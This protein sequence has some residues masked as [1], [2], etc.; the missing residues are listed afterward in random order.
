[1]IMVRQI[2]FNHQ[3]IDLNTFLIDAKSIIPPWEMG[4]EHFDLPTAPTHV[5]GWIQ[6]G[7][8]CCVAS[9]GVVICSFATRTMIFHA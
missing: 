2:H 4:N 1:M 6:R 8:F 5:H 9:T 3:K 7:R